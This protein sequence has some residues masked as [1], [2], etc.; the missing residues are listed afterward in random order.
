[1][2]AQRSGA[3]ALFAALLISS[4]CTV[5][6]DFERPAAPQAAPYG[7]G[8]LPVQTASAEVAGGAAQKFLGGRD[9]PGDW[10]TLFHSPALNG[11]I[12]DA[13]KAN[14]NLTAAQ[15]AL[16]QA[17]ELTLA[18]EGA[19]FPTVQG[20]FSP[21]RNKTATGA[22]SPASASGN[23]YYSLYTAQVSVSFVPDVFGATRRTVEN[24]A[25]LEEAQRY[26]VEA[27]YLTLTSNVVLA[28][29]QEASLRGQ[30]A[31]TQEIIKAESDALD[32][33][34]NQLKLGQAAG[35]DVAAQEAALAQ[36]EATLPPLQKA[37][38]Q[39]RDLIAALAGRFPSDTPSATFELAALQLPRELPVS[40]PSQL[41]DE[42]PDVR[43]AEAQ[44][45]AAS[46][47]IGVAIAAMLPQFSLTPNIG[48][49][50]NTLASMFGPGTSFWSLA[51]SAAQTIFD[52]GI[53]LHKKRAAEAELDQAAAQYRAAVLTA[54]QNVADSLR[55]L[56]DDG[57][58]LKAAAAAERAAATSLDI[59]R[60]QLA[61]G[62]IQY[63]ALLNA[64]QTYQQARVNLV[65]AQ[66]MRYADTAVLFQAL[67]GG[68]WNRDP[69]A[70]VADA[71]KR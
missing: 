34:H 51:G 42:R 53:L 35:G 2:I 24:L 44:M 9:I 10:W 33:L 54:F 1:M 67:G 69:V 40:L 17:H 57:N 11:L 60:R 23:P 71:E 18:G 12:E 4:G 8:G 58:A 47:E 64:E 68:W 50:S 32:I 41:V 30:I 52:G 63:L 48:T 59:T 46:A 65:Q 7:E 66:A 36:A 3:T 15:A 27:T 38:G 29:I 26:Q 61:L 45:H 21:S 28:A 16:H 70:A 25:A 31:A 5:G 22:L 14:P 55:A 13:L 43:A 20:S 19:F 62:A 6:P 37:L 56:Q 49:A 39:Q